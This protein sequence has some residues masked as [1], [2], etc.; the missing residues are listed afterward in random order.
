MRTTALYLS[1]NGY[2]SKEFDILQ[3]NFENGMMLTETLIPSINVNK[4]QR[5]NSSVTDFYSLS[6]SPLTFTVN[7]VF[8]KEFTDDDKI[9]VIRWLKQETYKPLIFDTKPDDVYY[10]VVTGIDF[11]HNTLKK[12]YFTVSFECNAPW[13]YTKVLMTDEF[14]ITNSYSFNVQSNSV[15]DT[16]IVKVILEVKADGNLLIKN[17]TN[18]TELNFTGLVNGTKMT[19]DCFNHSVEATNSSDETILVN[20]KKQNH[21][22]LELMAENN[23]IEVT[24]SCDLKIFWQGTRI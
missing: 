20:D 13:P 10:A 7:M 18:N 12:G 11:T 19:I 23:N 16:K 3:V 2:S 24:G 6:N 22:W 9:K 14:T 5:Q 4:T 8:D 17:K 21:S 15:F 1:F